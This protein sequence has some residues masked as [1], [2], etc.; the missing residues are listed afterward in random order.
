MPYM[1]KTC[2]Q[3]DHFYM[4]RSKGDRIVGNCRLSGAK[5]VSMMNAC[6][7]FAIGGVQGVQNGRK[8]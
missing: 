4:T 3:C 6:L 5:I 8:E 2:N 1:A 7:M